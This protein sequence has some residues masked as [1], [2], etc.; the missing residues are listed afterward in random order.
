MYNFSQINFETQQDR[1]GPVQNLLLRALNPYSLQLNWL[2]P[3][4]QNGVI[5][6]YVININSVEEINEKPWTI[7]I[8]SNQA[9]LFYSR[10]GS[11]SI[12]PINGTNYPPMEAIV[13]NLIGGKSYRINVVGVTEAG[14]REPSSPNE[15]MEIR[16][17]I[18]GKL[19]N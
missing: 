5:S 13:D 16:M 6:H 10:D 11:E 9:Q 18:A 14:P 2:A 4:L 15:F 17:P 7:N 3:I 19:I 1:P 12:L 8:A